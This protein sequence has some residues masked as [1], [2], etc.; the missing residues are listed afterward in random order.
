MTGN[1]FHRIVVPTDFSE[2]AEEAWAL[3]RRIAGA[4]GSEIVLVHVFV[5]PPLYGEAPLTP[6]ATWQVF[7]EA[8]QWVENE[9]DK[10]TAAARSKGIAARKAVRTGSPPQQIIEVVADEH[11]DLVVIGTHGRG[12]V[13]RALLGSVADRV[14]RM[15]SCP[16]LTVRKSD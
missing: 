10:W 5:D 3:A 2:C 15:A 11:A 13:S 7:E 12:G 8:R 1:L 9:L 14:V 16:V 6:A 4:V